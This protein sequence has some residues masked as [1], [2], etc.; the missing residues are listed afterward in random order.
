MSQKKKKTARTDYGEIIKIQEKDL[1]NKRI[2]G[3]LVDAWCWD[4]GSKVVISKGAR[5][6]RRLRLCVHEL[7]HVCFPEATE[8]EVLR[9]EKIMTDVL[10]AE[11]YRKT[12]NKIF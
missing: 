9:A 6:K 11:G 3:R 2:N 1:K 5:G 12:D 4:D 7:M 10:W 8:T